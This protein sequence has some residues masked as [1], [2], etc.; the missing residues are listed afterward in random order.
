MVALLGDS[1]W[2]LATAVYLAFAS[3]QVAFLGHDTGHRQV[4]ATRRANGVL[5]LVIGNLLIGLSFGWWVGKHNRH[6][7]HPNQLDAD[8]DIT[9]GAIAFTTEQALNK[10][11][12]TRLVARHQA[13][14]LFPLL[15]LEAAHLHA[16]S[17]K[18]LARGEVRPTSIE[19]ML[20]AAH[21][22]GYLAA[23]LLVLSPL[24]MAVFLVVQQGLFGVYLGVRSRPTTRACPCS[25]TA[26][27]RASCGA[28]C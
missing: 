16:A 6:H 23:L 18:A 2:Q 15:P 11:G 20:L 26:R 7:S 14:L 3:T 24:K 5:G 25:P 12:F 9:I 19:T 21:G 13:M 17:F 1:W 8:P 28:R 22:V 10:R 4:F 27:S